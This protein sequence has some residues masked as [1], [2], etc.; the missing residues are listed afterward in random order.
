[1]KY[2]KKE[3]FSVK[4]RSPLRGKY[5]RLKMVF[6]LGALAIHIN[7]VKICIPEEVASILL[8]GR[9][10]TN[11]LYSWEKTCVINYYRL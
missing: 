5:I 7:F 9:S 2:L 3:P 10:Y 4:D 1:M 6:K 11:I 8:Q